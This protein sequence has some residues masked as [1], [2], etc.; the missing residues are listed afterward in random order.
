M[1][2]RARQHIMTAVCARRRCG[3]A[4]CR[5]FRRR[6][7]GSP[8]GPRRIWSHRTQIRPPTPRHGPTMA[9]VAAAAPRPKRRRTAPRY[10]AMACAGSRANAAV[11]V[12]LAAARRLPGTGAMWPAAEESPG[13]AAERSPFASWPRTTPREQPH[14]STL[15]N[16]STPRLFTLNFGCQ[17]ALRAAR[18]WPQPPSRRAAGASGG[19][20]GPTPLGQGL[21]RSGSS[22][23][24]NSWNGSCRWPHAVGVH[25]SQRLEPGTT[26]RATRSKESDL[27][28]SVQ[29][30][31]G[32]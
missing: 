1:S 19:P 9:V 7:I 32:L 15:R 20:A 31:G 8:A 30:I 18:G 5:R 16:V 29:L 2:A 25:G 22:D 27:M 28:C 10:P 6:R 3:R 14:K 21:D 13:S 12:A 26:R 17:R 24:P 4:H 23:G 11:R